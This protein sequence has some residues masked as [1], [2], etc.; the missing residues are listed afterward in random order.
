ME[1]KQ[2]DGV[3]LW[4]PILSLAL[5]FLFNPLL[6]ERQ[7]IPSFQLYS[8]TN[9]QIFTARSLI[10]EKGTFFAIG[11]NPKKQGEIEQWMQK[12]EPLKKEGLLGRVIEVA[13]MEP[14]Y[15]VFHNQTQ[16]FMKKSDSS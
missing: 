4:I 6:A 2:R 7:I 12:V 9:N 16:A 1:K 5:S 8:L 13:V 10:D 11:F 3:F 15:K 14:H